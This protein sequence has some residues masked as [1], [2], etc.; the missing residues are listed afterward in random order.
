MRLTKSPV[1]SPSLL[2]RLT[3]LGLAAPNSTAKLQANEHT[4]S[5]FRGH[6]RKPGGCG[7]RIHR[8]L[9]TVLDD[10]GK[11][12]KRRASRCSPAE[13]RP[14]VLRLYAIEC[15]ISRDYWFA[16]LSW[17]PIC[18]AAP[19]SSRVPQCSALFPLTIRKKCVCWIVYLRPVG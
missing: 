8:G 16:G 12:S 11:W 19:R 1:G 4:K 15:R 10:C 2:L 18:L 14:H 6:L 17:S 7:D 5:V 13:L 9:W 3:C